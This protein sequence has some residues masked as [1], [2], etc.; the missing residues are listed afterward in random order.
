MKIDE[1]IQ[2][3]SSRGIPFEIREYSDEAEF[4]KSIMTFPRL[5]QAAY[6]KTKAIVIRSKNGHKDIFLQFNAFENEYVFV[7]LFFGEFAFELLADYDEEKLPA[8]LMRFIDLIIDCKVS[9]IMLNDLKKKKWIGDAVNYRD[10]EDSEQIFYKIVEDGMNKPLSLFE[11]LFHVRKQYE[12]YDFKN[13]KCI[14]KE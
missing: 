7:D 12:V 14:I 4:F 9:I 5:F 13:Y 8:Q 2:L 3:I 10:E 11:R 6:C 1:A